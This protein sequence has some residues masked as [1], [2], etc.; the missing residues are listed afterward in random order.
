MKN[1]TFAGL[2]SAALA[3]IMFA[4]TSFYIVSSQ[5]HIVWVNVL[6]S[7]S[8]LPTSLG[9]VFLAV[10]APL[11]LIGQEKPKVW[12]MQLHV[13]LPVIAAGFLATLASGFV[14]AGS[15][16]GPG[17]IAWAD[18]GFPLPWRV[19]VFVSC[20]PL[21]NQ[22]SGTVF[23]PVFFAID[24]VFFL[25]FSSTLALVYKILGRRSTPEGSPPGARALNLGPV[26][27]GWA[28]RSR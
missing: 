2:T 14:S 13:M 27:N 16:F 11:F 17:G 23:N 3:G 15:T 20:P 21:C 18:Y 19:D 9:L 26:R 4:G 7:L 24:L 25:A 22:T 5:A 28:T 10:S 6:G 1:T 8:L 12:L